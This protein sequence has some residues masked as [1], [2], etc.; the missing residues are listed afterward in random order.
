MDALS[1]VKSWKT[2]IAGVVVAGLLLWPSVAGLIDGDPAT[3]ID[4]TTFTIAMGL[5]G[6]G[7]A[8]KDGD[9]TSADL[10]L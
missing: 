10:N 7:V 4:W 2:T 1:L 6:L 3:G 8:A 5:L 9:K